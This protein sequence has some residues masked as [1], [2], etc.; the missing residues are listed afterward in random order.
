[1]ITKKLIL[2]TAIICAFVSTANAQQAPVSSVTNT[3]IPA[4]RL[5]AAAD[6]LAATGLSTQMDGMYKS[7]ID[8]SSTQIPAE[9]KEKFSQILKSFLKKY[10]SYDMLKNDLAKIYAEEFTEQ[11]LKDITK[12]YL[13]P[14]GKKV[15]QKLSALM[16]RGIQLG[17]S[18]MQAH[19]P[20]FQEELKKAFPG[21]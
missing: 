16:Q 5:Q 4:S 15:N 6:M 19:L 13:T 11:E 18:R 7:M 9:N 12:F 14:T 2:F 20:E 21:Q 3:T 8:A 1:M 10:M 17:Q